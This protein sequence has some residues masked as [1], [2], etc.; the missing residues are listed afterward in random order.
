MADSSALTPAEQQV[1]DETTLELAITK[2]L[3]FAM[4]DRTTVTKHKW[5]E[6]ENVEIGKDK[7]KKCDS[8]WGKFVLC[9][10][11]RISTSAGVPGTT[12]TRGADGYD[13]VTIK[14]PWQEGDADKNYRDFSVALDNLEWNKAPSLSSTK[15]TLTAQEIRAAGRRAVEIVS[16][17]SKQISKINT[18][19]GGFS[20][21]A[22]EALAN[23]L[24]DIRATFVHIEYTA[25]AGNET[26]D[27]NGKKEYTPRDLSGAL[28]DYAKA[29]K[30]FCGAIETAW[31]DWKGR[32]YRW[33]QNI[34]QGLI[35]VIINQYI[36]GDYHWKARSDWNTSV[37]VLG[38][39]DGVQ[40]LPSVDLGTADGWAQVDDYGKNV[41]K[42]LVKDHLDDP[43]KKAAKDLC[44]AM[45]VAYA[46]F[47]A[48]SY[49]PAEDSTK[50]AS[51]SDKGG[52]DKKGG[53]DDKSGY[54][55][56]FDNAGGGDDKSGYDGP[57][58]NAGGGDDKSGY[59]S[60]FDNAGGGDDKSGYDSPFD[61]AGGGDDK[62][63]YDSPFDNAGG[64]DDKSGYENPLDKS[65]YSP[66]GTWAAPGN[67]G[68][69]DSGS[70]RSGFPSSGSYYE[71]E[72]SDLDESS[73]FPDSA[74]FP[75]A[76]SDD[77]GYSG[78]DGADGMLGA[79]PTSGD[80]SAVDGAAS[81]SGGYGGMPMGG[82]G[83]MGNMGG[84]GQQEKER[85]R[86]VWEPE[87]EDVWGTDPECSPAVLGRFDDAPAATES[88]R[89]SQ[90]STRRTQPG[91]T[92]TRHQVRGRG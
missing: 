30:D 8:K 53:G 6:F 86:T 90:Q 79:L 28:D 10:G 18:S 13:I 73:G 78:A 24:K 87:E 85:D 51:N 44:I 39:P 16:D 15:T 65:G 31:N 2:I 4:P 92:P 83:G 82:M 40:H 54:D 26:L 76:L 47:N 67:L 20:G 3:G 56:P 37:Y 9:R 11:R 36:E 35:D 59:D 80:G 75:T 55:G 91:Q 19:A 69:S 42:K 61:N 52:T 17:L 46:R 77:G 41:W 88:A 68:N 43:I 48:M 50:T 63:G 45:N 84:A 81:S 72:G 33:P 71:S 62:S 12:Q 58:D 32:P 49:D 23:A 70:Y 25:L 57:F 14:L 64:D 7:S 34:V 1:I 21:S 60:P 38:A 27:P 22:A 89:P 66:L 29:Q 5:L 74:L